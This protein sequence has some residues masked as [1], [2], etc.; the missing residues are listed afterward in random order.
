MS[1]KRRA[2]SRAERRRLYRRDR[3]KCQICFEPFL[4]IAK[5]RPICNIDHMKALVN[6][7]N[8]THSSNLRCLCL[9]CH[10]KKTMFDLNPDLWERVT[11]LSKWFKGPKALTMNHL[12]EYY[13]ELGKLNKE[14][15]YQK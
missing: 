5:D 4:R 3:Y 6:G 7:G 15:L 14:M 11:G 12:F 8:D 10:G 13:E 9:N 1:C 2:L